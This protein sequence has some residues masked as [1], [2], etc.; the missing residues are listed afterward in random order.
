M[1]RHLGRRAFG[2]V[3][4]LG[5]VLG[6]GALLRPPATPAAPAEIAQVPAVA[7]PAPS[8]VWPAP[9]PD[10]PAVLPAS[11]PV[12]VQIP[13]ISVDSVLMDL[14]LLPDGTLEVPSTAFP[15]GWYTGAPTPGERGPA[16]IAGHV[17]LDRVPGVFHD[18]AALQPG[19]LVVVDRQDGGQATFV[20][21]AVGSY[22]KDM[23]PTAAVYGDTAGPQL[24]LITCG[25][26][27]DSS[28]GH[29]EDNVVV[30]A[31]LVLGGSEG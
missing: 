26:E 29:Y 3:T 13:A 16:V 7:V 20:V 4:V 5:L 17:D 8:A 15:A 27:F 18:L 2:V 28:V 19:D 14:G 9:V 12:R 6:Y 31:S 23:F 11:V 25:G 21:D 22:P 24:R 30:F 1:P 10:L